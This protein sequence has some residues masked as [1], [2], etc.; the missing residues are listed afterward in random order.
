MGSVASVALATDR[1]ASA[2]SVASAID[3]ASITGRA[4]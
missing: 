3:P 4:G 1:V 2:G